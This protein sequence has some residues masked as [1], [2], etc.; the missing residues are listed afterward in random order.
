M[1]AP[2]THN[3]VMNATTTLTAAFSAGGGPAT[4]RSTVLAD[5]PRF[6][7]GLGDATGGFADVTGNGNAGTASGTGLSRGAA[8]HRDLDKRRGVASTDGTSSM[9]AAAVS[10]L[11]ATVVS[12]EVWF[13]AS[14]YANWSDLA[15]HNWGG[16]GGSGWGLYLNASRQLT[17]GLWQSGS[18]EKN[19]RS[20]ALTANLIY[21]AVGTYDGSVIRL[22][23]NGALVGSSTVGAITLNTAASVFTGQD[24]YDLAAHGGRARRLRGEPLGRAGHAHY[25]AGK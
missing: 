10:G 19:V 4:Y 22:Y 17:W 25:N 21:H 13:R 14:A 15:S 12:V 23:L 6:L 8:G 18:A 1:P 11:S 2:P 9:P 3:I 20:A 16:A 24:R 7:W 5:G